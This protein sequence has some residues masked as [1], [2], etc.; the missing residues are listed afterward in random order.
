MKKAEKLYI[1]SIRLNKNDW[2]RFAKFAKNR[3]KAIRDFIAD[4]IK[5]RKKR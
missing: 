4:V 5:E 2:D 3:S 1:A